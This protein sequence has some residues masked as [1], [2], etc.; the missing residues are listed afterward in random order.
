LTPRGKP[1]GGK[2]TPTIAKPWPEGAPRGRFLV[3][4]NV[5]I[6]WPAEQAYFPGRI[7]SYDKFSGVYGVEYDDGE[8]EAV[9]LNREDWKYD[10]SSAETPAKPAQADLSQQTPPAS[11]SSNA[12]S[13]AAEAAGDTAKTV[14]SAVSRTESAPKR[15]RGGGTRESQAKR[16]K[17][18][19]SAGG[20]S[21]SD[22]E[23]DSS[24][25]DESLGGE[26]FVPEEEALAEKANVFD[27]EADDDANALAF[28]DVLPAASKPAASKKSRPAPKKSA[29][30]PK[31]KASATL[32]SVVTS[33]SSGMASS[34]GGGVPAGC[35]SVEAPRGGWQVMSAALKEGAGVTPAPSHP[36]PM[37]DKASMKATVYRFGEHSHNHLDFLRD[38]RDGSG[39]R[40]GDE[41]FDPTS[42]LIP[43]SHMK[44]CTP[45]QHQ[46]WELKANHMDTI[47]CFKMGKFY[48]AYHMDADVIVRELDCIYM[49]G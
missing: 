4:K 10:S 12:A 42:L 9:D 25:D 37:S 33:S 17:L 48:E 1:K 29:S 13:S 44:D 14:S 5:S 27:D 11:S 47:L 26:G 46:W 34:V 2:S 30:S 36:P 20:D 39:K 38:R 21:E 3:G 23:A 41:G 18:V 24:S 32:D 49:K 16:R 7:I 15:A 40:P 8:M 22:F 28:D 6:F 31:A 19:K 35:L 45:G 43:P